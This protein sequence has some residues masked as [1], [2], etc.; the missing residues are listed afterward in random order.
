MTGELIPQPIEE[1]QA[2]VDAGIASEAFFVAG[3]LNVL[4]NR[5]PGR[6]DMGVVDRRTA[7]EH[8]VDACGG[9]WRRVRGMLCL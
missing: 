9:A 3:R 7:I 8:A 1:F 6:I 2:S 4:C 5:M